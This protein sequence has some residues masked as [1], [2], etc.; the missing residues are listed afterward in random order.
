MFR[1]TPLTRPPGAGTEER[2]QT[3]EIE[4][5]SA[6]HEEVEAAELLVDAREHGVDV[7]IRRDVARQNQRRLFEPLRQ[8]VD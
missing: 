2:L 7:G 8:V 6:V 3:G 1:P 5:G 4:R